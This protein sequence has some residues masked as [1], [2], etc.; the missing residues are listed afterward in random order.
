MILHTASEGITLAKELETISASFYEE[1]AQRYREAAEFFLACAKEN[2]KNIVQIERAYY[3]VITDALEGGYAFNLE[4]SEYEINTELPAETDYP[5]VLKKAI[6]TEEKIIK[7]Y[8]DAANQSSGLM[9]DVPRT[10]TLVA[11]K[12]SHRV[13]ELKA[14]LG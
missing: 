2:G 6:E 12:R 5:A 10:F 11:K 9:A 8:T 7:F 1:L 13:D 4:T 14:L 3:G